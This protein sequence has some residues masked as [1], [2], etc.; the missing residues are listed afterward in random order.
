MAIK[1]SFNFL[2]QA[3]VDVPHLRSI[4]SAVRNDFDEMFAAFVLGESNSY[5]I[6]GFD[7]EM[8]GSIGASANGLQLIVEDSAILH[9]ASNESGTFFELPPGEANQVLSATTNTR[10]EGAFTPGALNYVSLEF[11]RQVDDTTTDQI[12]LWNPTTQSEITKTLPLAE[13]L[14]YKIVISSSLFTSN[15]LPISIVETDASNNVLSIQDRRPMLFR[16]GTAGSATPDPFYEYAWDNHTEGRS[17]N[18]WQ[19]SSSTSSPF[20]GGD[21]QIRTFKENDE[22][23]KTEIKQIKGTTYWYSANNAGSLTGI[24]YDLGNTIFT[25]RGYIEHNAGNPGQINWDEDMFLTVVTTRLKYKLEANVATTNIDLDDDQVAYVKLIRDVD[26]IPQLVFTN[27]ADEVTSVGAIAWTTDL[28][29]GDYVKVGAEDDSAYYQIL[30]V[31]S[32]SQVTL[33]ENFGGTSTGINGTDAKIAYGNYR[34]DAA[35]STDR[36]IRVAN[37]NE[38]PFDKDVY[39]LFLRSDNAGQARVYLRFL[40]AELEVGEQIQISDQVPA[41]VLAYM[42]SAND[43][44]AD[45]EY[46][47]LATGVKAGTT[48]YNSVDGENLTIRASKLTSMMAD[49]AQ[50]KTI[51]ILSDHTSVINTTNGGNPLL[52]DLTFSGGSGV[53]TVAMPSS[54]NNGTIGLTSTLEL[55]ENQAAYFSVDR[56]A[57]FNLADLDSLTVSNIDSIALNENN[58]I[59]AYRTTGTTIYLWDGSAY[60]I[61][62]TLAPY[63]VRGY[64]QQNK[65]VKLV[66][67]GTWNWNLATNTLSNSLSAYL[68]VAGLAEN[69][70]EIAQ[71]NIVLAADGECAYVTLKR[72][73]GAS[74]LTVNVADITS[75]PNDD[76]TF[77][78]ARRTGDDVLIGRSF[79]LKDT[80][81]LELDG[82]LA[83]I[84]RYFG[85][86]RLIPHESDP[87]KVRVTG[88][89]V[90][91]LSGT[92]LSSAI[93]NRLV[94]FDG[95]VVDFETGD[96]FESDG[97]TPLDNSFTP[98]T[99]AADQFR[100]Y[101]ITL[102]A[103]TIN[104]NNTVG[105]ELNI[106]EAA[107][108]GATAELA[109]RASFIDGIGIGQVYVQEDGSGGIEGIEYENII[110]LGVIGGAASSAVGGSVVKKDDVLE[111]SNVST[112]DFQGDGVEIVDEGAGEVAIIIDSASDSRIIQGFKAGE[113]FDVTGNG[114]PFA[115]YPKR[116]RLL[117]FDASNN[118]LE[119][120]EGSIT[121]DAGSY[122]YPYT[123]LKSQMET[124]LN[125]LGSVVFTVTL[126]EQHTKIEADSS[127]TINKTAANSATTKL[128]YVTLDTSVA[129][130]FFRADS[131]K[132]FTVDVFLYKTNTTDDATPPNLASDG[133]TPVAADWRS[134]SF[135]GFVQEDLS[136]LDEAKLY[137]SGTIKGFSGLNEADNYYT[138]G[139]A[140]QV[141]TTSIANSL[142]IGEVLADGSGL[143]LDAHNKDFELEI[144]PDTDFAFDTTDGV[145]T[146]ELLPEVPNFFTSDVALHGAGAD[147]NNVVSAQVASDTGG[148]MRIPYSTDR[149]KS[150]KFAN[151]DVV[152]NGI[153]ETSVATRTVSNWNNTNEYYSCSPKVVVFGDNVFVAYS[154]FDTQQ[155][156]RGLYGRIDSNGNLTLKQS[157]EFKS[158]PYTSSL[159]ATSSGIDRGFA[160][161]LEYKNGVIY[162]SALASDGF[163]SIWES[164]DGGATF[165]PEYNV[166][167]SSTAIDTSINNFQDFQP[168]RLAVVDVPGQTIGTSNNFTDDFSAG[169]AGWTKE[170]AATGGVIHDAVNELLTFDDTSGAS[171][172]ANRVFTTEV[173]K[174]YTVRVNIKDI[175]IL[176]TLNNNRLDVKVGDAAGALSGGFM[177]TGLV[178]SAD[179]AIGEGIWEFTF[180]ANATS[181]RFQFGSETSA[182]TFEV[183]IDDFSV[184]EAAQN[185]VAV[186]TPSTNGVANGRNGLYYTDDQDLSANWAAGINLGEDLSTSAYAPPIG[187]YLADDGKLYTHHVTSHGSANANGSTARAGDTDASLIVETDL[188]QVTPSV[189]KGTLDWD[190]SNTSPIT[191]DN[192]E[193]T[194]NSNLRSWFNNPLN[195]YKND[196]GVYAFAMLDNGDAFVSITTDMANFA[197]STESIKY[198]DYANNVT[199]G[200]SVVQEGSFLEAAGALQLVH[201]RGFGSYNNA[202]LLGKVVASTLTTDL[203]GPT[204]TIEFSNEI[205][206]IDKPNV[207]EQ[208]FAGRIQALVSDNTA[209]VFAEAEKSVEGTDYEQVVYNNYGLK[210]ISVAQQWQ[211]SP[212]EVFDA[213]GAD[214]TQFAFKYDPQNPLIGISIIKRSGF[215][216]WST[217]TTSDGGDSWQLY[218]NTSVD[219]EQ[220]YDNDNDAYAFQADIDIYDGKF[221]IAVPVA[222]GG[223]HT[224]SRTYY[225]N[226]DTTSGEITSITESTYF[227]GSTLEDAGAAAGSQLQFQ[228]SPDGSA[229]FVMSFRTSNGNLII[230]RSDD[231]GAT[232][233]SKGAVKSGASAVAFSYNSGT[234]YSAHTFHVIEDPDTPNNWRVIVSGTNQA[235]NGR[236]SIHYTD[237]QNLANNWETAV[238]LTDLSA[239]T[240]DFITGAELS[241]NQSKLALTTRS[242]NAS[243]TNTFLTIADVGSTVITLS[244]NSVNTG[245]SHGG[246]DTFNGNNSD[247]TE[248]GNFTRNIQ[249]RRIIWEGETALLYAANGD[250][251]GVGDFQIVKIA[252]VTN[253]A[254]TASITRFAEASSG[255]D[256]RKTEGQIFKLDNGEYWAVCKAAD[257]TQATWQDRGRI[258]TKQFFNPSPTVDE[259]IDISPSADVSA[260]NDSI[261][262]DLS[263]KASAGTPFAGR[264]LA[265]KAGNALRIGFEMDNDLGFE[266]VFINNR[267]TRQINEEVEEWRQIPS[268]NEDAAVDTLTYGFDKSGD[269]VIL[270]R[271]KGSDV[272]I[273]TST[274]KGQNWNTLGSYASGAGW[275]N[276]GDYIAYSPRVIVNGNEAC[277][278]HSNFPT[279]DVKA[280]KLTKSGGVWS[281]GTEVQASSNTNPRDI[282]IAVDKTNN[283]LFSGGRSGLGVNYTVNVS[284]DMGATWGT[285]TLVKN[286]V[287]DASLEPA[288]PVYMEAFDIGS[289]TTRLAVIGFDQGVTNPRFYFT[290]D[291]GTTWG[292]APELGPALPGNV[293]LY[294][295]KRNGNKL[296]ALLYAVGDTDGLYLTICDDITVASPTFSAPV[297]IADGV[298][299]IDTF[300]GYTSLSTTLEWRKHLLSSIQW[301]SSTSLIC[302]LDREE[303]G[304][305][306]SSLAVIIPDTSSPGT[307]TVV[308]VFTG[309]TSGLGTMQESQLV[310][311]SFGDIYLIAKDSSALGSNLSTGRI[312]AKQVFTDGSLGVIQDIGYK[313][314]VTTGG[315]A[316]RIQVAPSD[317]AAIMFEK[318]DGSSIEQTYFNSIE[319]R[320]VQK[321]ENPDDN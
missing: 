130:T 311:A 58:F 244:Q 220:N 136:T 235:G 256:Y 122:V 320:R 41:A 168:Y 236:V 99:I 131:N 127:F 184:T 104:A 121:I 240:V 186:V 25:G 102:T 155:R 63:L 209:H 238:D 112:F 309:L 272:H 67:G 60:E 11:T 227:A 175:R 321:D 189:Q 214:T 271:S 100:Y 286:G 206:I 269:D 9:G 147:G 76:H 141:S 282:R 173:G 133:V 42:G 107:T 171:S 116:K 190:T 5:V 16:L 17:E 91:K 31:D 137:V 109:E 262:I 101:S 304:G 310:K 36:H 299:N 232:W 2:N 110:Q 126:L 254:A 94:A 204:P 111:A 93:L 162:I 153:N 57:A 1:R 229:L 90:S 97:I 226:I 251:N 88:G 212:T 203:T 306:R 28:E 207:D 92:E 248:G 79:L 315:F 138:N 39:W 318:E 198:N 86:F 117:T 265:Q 85:Q 146:W 292:T 314:D 228:R 234:S 205:D 18:F 132:D 89:D 73:A 30:T 120:S 312:L 289:G 66:K 287:T 55:G 249:R 161:N 308:S 283:K 53:A 128:G 217:W 62:E 223:T 37:I 316:G 201:K 177:T 69:V 8:A 56:N 149:G 142:L 239:V 118:V 274:D 285:Q 98:A 54:T 301:T 81:F 211:S 170:G 84:N 182:D 124:K 195:V 307:N 253:I 154:F 202:E 313:S 281:V 215:N 47:T 6:R 163:L 160:R 64:A 246:S 303:T 34:T 222:V 317:N 10:V 273:W 252:D 106:Q 29:A 145:F 74:V 115:V 158:S 38:V 294:G 169:I 250:V 231:D 218:D 199:G 51:R 52:Q 221:C 194:N 233:S 135:S 13:T 46:S 7:I 24:R 196:D 193:G 243:A 83:E 216:A 144:E 225:G 208:G 267:N 72:T 165:E 261:P 139:I 77:I 114:A 242:L 295:V 15:V 26:V 276:A 105:F 164:K 174:S 213:Q 245:V 44:D 237:D 268:R 96:V 65:N 288:S 3:R 103:G 192:G 4:E 78:F 119:T 279:D 75:V 172:S 123:S 191:Q 255:G 143:F 230:N 48:N 200:N 298:G 156:L 297:D 247:N 264:I 148:T 87:N 219:S 176:G 43:S 166:K 113:D 129:S 108:D 150:W 280:V 21:K 290:D 70:N 27:G 157:N 284:S 167:N 32:A 293:S 22:A 19:S 224:E 187:A 183:D 59:F 125:T 188:A 197:S 12:Y 181:T 71:Q 151:L 152:I 82:A 134:R 80:E 95:A 210:N 50:D 260:N 49:K 180:E 258:Y 33:T 300:T 20:R 291:G 159:S 178:Y 257:A 319:L 296:A 278:L 40:N 270:A 45:P 266:G 23:L 68:Q 35:P 140:G 305:E 302:C 61:G 185:R 241:P 14:D 277:M 263:N 275:N 259:P 179:S